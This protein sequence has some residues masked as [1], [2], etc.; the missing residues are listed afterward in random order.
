M[1]TLRTHISR[2]PP[3]SLLSS[4]PPSQ[5]YVD[6]FNRL[7]AMDTAHPAFEL[8]LSWLWDILDEFIY[9]FQTFHLFRNKVSQ[10]TQEEVEML[11]ENEHMWSAQTVVQYLHALVRKAGL[12]L[13]VKAA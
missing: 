11:K 1:H 12:D 9:Q 2:A 3:S 10:L 6:L 5:N 8:P 4:L 7:L 13:N